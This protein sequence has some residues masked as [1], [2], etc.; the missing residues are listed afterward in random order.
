M[1]QIRA[2]FIHLFIYET[3]LTSNG[4]EIC[5]SLE[6]CK[7]KPIFFMQ[8]D[9]GQHQASLLCLT[10]ILGEVLGRT[11]GTFLSWVIAYLSLYITSIITAIAF[12]SLVFKASSA[13]SL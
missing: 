9:P 8:I 7:Y 13:L 4:N 12:S 3:T 10:D 6:Q 1:L 5:F 11:T 2:I